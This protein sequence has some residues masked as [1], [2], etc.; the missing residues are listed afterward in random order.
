MIYVIEIEV[1]TEDQALQI[2]EVLE[3][4]E[5]MGDLDFAFGTR[6]YNRKE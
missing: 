5:E 2:Q 1:E 6:I 4:A 3:E